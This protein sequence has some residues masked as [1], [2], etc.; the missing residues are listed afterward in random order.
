MEKLSVYKKKYKIE[1]SDV[2]FRKKIKLSSLFSFFQDIASSAVDNLGIGINTI[3]KKGIAWILI[4]SRVDII[5]NPVWNQEI[6]IETWP[7]LP[8]TLEFERDFV[9]KDINGNVMIKAVSTWIIIDINT[10]RIKKSNLIAIDYP[11]IVKERAINCKLGK[12]KPFGNLEV[13]YKKVIGYSDI[14]FNGHL[15]NSKYI[16]FIMDCFTYENHQQYFVKS[17]EVNFNSELLPGEVLVLYRD[18]SSLNDNHIY[19]EGIKEKD[20]KIAV[21]ALVEITMKV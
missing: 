15:N 3:E 12:I 18:I 1:L 11:D 20:E 16:D 8:K 10:R 7:Q 2:D 14:D 4:R 5:K 19:I 21:K 9:V 6:I 17:I 13:A